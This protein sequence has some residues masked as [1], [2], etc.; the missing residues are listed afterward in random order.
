MGVANDLRDAGQQCDLL[1]R[2]LGVT[3]RH[4]DFAAWIV[5]LDAANSRARVLFGSSSNCAGIKHYVISLGCDLGAVHAA[6]AK[7]LLDSRSIRLSRAA[8]EIFYV[9][10]G[11]A[12]ILAYIHLRCGKQ[13]AHRDL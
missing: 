6:V 2:T 1:G 9:K 11:H 5:P 4:N 13:G 7:L 10:T 8:T 3:S 12:P